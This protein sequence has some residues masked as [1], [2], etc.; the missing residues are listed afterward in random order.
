[1]Q[2]TASTTSPV[3]LFYS[4]SHKDEQLRDE[5]DEHLALLK[6]RGVLRTWHD[7]KIEAGQDWAAGID[8]NLEA[9]DIILLLISPSFLNS[10]YCYDIEM[11]R[12]MERHEAGLARLIPVI[13]RSVDLE[14]APFASMQALP[15]DAKPVTSWTNRDEA[16]TDVAKGIRKVADELGS[17]K[18]ALPP[19]ALPHRSAIS[20]DEDR[21]SGDAFS[22]AVSGFEKQMASAMLQK[23]LQE[24][25]RVDDARQVAERLADLPDQKRLLWVDDHPENNVSEIASLRKMQIEV[26]AVTSTSEALD[27]LK[28][29]EAFY[30]LVISDW[31]RFPRIIPWQP[32]GIRLLHKM[33]KAGSAV[34]VLFYHGTVD[35]ETLQARREQVLR[36][37]G[38]GA[39]YRPDELLEQ[40]ARLLTEPRKDAVR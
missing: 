26:D 6:R 4:Y 11:K 15:K 27:R 19:D 28:P 1:M 7:R 20:A 2:D 24:E 40:V 29:T 22:R 23:Q 21:R 18:G 37:K 33:R 9:A 34:P 38:Q 17:L 30:D 39:T 5:L 16:W 12:G 36:E 35:T 8:A 3:D 31:E 14:G 10:N 25:F 32:E 13:I